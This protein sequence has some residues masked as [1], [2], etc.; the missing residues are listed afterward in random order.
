MARPRLL[1]TALF[2]LTACSEAPPALPHVPVERP[3]EFVRSILR[4]EA[5]VAELHET[6]AKKLEQSAP[7]NIAIDAAGRFPDPREGR[8]VPDAALTIRVVDGPGDV[9]LSRKEL[10]A[11]LSELTAGW[12]ELSRASFEL[13][14]FWLDVS[15]GR[16]TGR[17]E[18][19]LAG[20]LA[21]GGRADLRALFDVEFSK[22]LVGG[23]SLDVLDLFE[24]TTIEGAV[25]LF[26]DVTAA[27]GFT[28]GMSPAN[29]ALLQDFIDEHRVLALSG[30]SACD[31]NRD[32]HPDVIACLGGSL[33]TLFLNDGQ[34]GF[35]PRELPIEAPN[36]AGIS[37]LYADLDGDG[38]EEL[39]SSRVLRFEGDQASCGLYVRDG[40][41]WSLDE[42]AF[43]FRNDVGLRGV[44]VQTIVPIDIDEDGDL[45]LFFGVYG[46]HESR[47]EEYNL[48]EAHDGGYNHLFVNQGDLKF[49]EETSLRGLGGKQYTY[50]ALP[51]DFDHDGDTDLFEGNDFGPNV[52]WVNDGGGRF[53]PK[54]D[55]VFEGESAY[56]MGVTLADHDDDGEFSMYVVNMSSEAGERI[57]RIA[58]DISERT[59]ERVLTIAGGNFL[60]TDRAATDGA[61][62]GWYEHARAARVAEG[63]WGWGAMF[64]DLDG[65]GD[66]ELLA[67]N[68]FTSHADPDLPDWDSLFWRQVAT[69]GALLER[70]ERTFDVNADQNFSGSYAG[71]QRDRLFYKADS[72]DD[73]FY[74]AAWHFGLDHIEDG[75]CVVPL[76]VDGDGDLDIVAYTLQGLRLYENRSRVGAVAVLRLE[77]TASHRYALG[78]TV[79]ARAGDL[80]QHD[81]VQLVEGFQSQVPLELHF[82]WRAAEQLDEVTVTWPSG[83]VQT[84]SDLPL[85]QHLT[86]VEGEDEVRARQVPRWSDDAAEL[87]AL[88][89]EVTQ[90]FVTVVR[91]G[92]QD[93]AWP[94]RD[95]LKPAHRDVLFE[96]ATGEAPDGATFVFDAGGALRRAFASPPSAEDLEG[97]L[98]L[99]IDEPPFPEL[100]MLAG[101]RRLLD[102]QVEKALAHFEAAHAGDPSLPGAAEGLARAHRRLGNLAEAERYYLRS[103][104]IDP[105]YAV[106]HF[107]LGVLW[108]RAG[109]GQD[110]LAAYGESLRIRGEHGPTLMAMGEAAL[111]AQDGELA[112]ELFRRAGDAEPRDA[113]PYVLRGKLL[114]QQRR[115]REAKTAFE[116]A[117][118]RAPKNDEAKRGLERVNSL[119]AG[120]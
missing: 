106:G 73:V 95:A 9:L 87:A 115:L 39:V 80:E 118:R 17:A 112:L 109:R 47:G 75:R 89:P 25:P 33:A 116:E 101:R 42:A 108:L 68:G 97:F 103:I 74:D 64:C 119:L 13:D 32:G 14:R 30:L 104:E 3:A 52:L 51:H 2:A 28:F 34:G 63:E 29:R 55:S 86:L 38:F 102:G 49:R 36:D 4:S 40:D 20:P 91:I 61:E 56:T 113:E 99:L 1:L 110:A 114:G 98:D 53:E 58:D 57:G 15:G 93:A 46:T 5:A 120:G 37:A 100:S 65:D 48:V 24:C 84:W 59:R 27:T 117:L 83:L 11:R 31:W 10:R 67:T 96:S 22:G 85:G 21:S 18:L 54:G 12:T 88:A 6:M 62:R 82:A 16:A 69:D 70:G 41:G 72:D 76:D 44:G 66:E 50:V 111:V 60:Y 92:A 8:L 43:T 94:A 19:Y 7:G 23:W 45:D 26:R 105:D 35:V 107:N 77:A 79:T 90:R 71:Y 78:A 81:I